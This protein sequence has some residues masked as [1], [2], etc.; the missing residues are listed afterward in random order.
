MTTTIVERQ[1]EATPAREK[2]WAW[3]RQH[4]QGG[5]K[6]VCATCGAI[7]GV[8]EGVPSQRASPSR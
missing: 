8:D 1:P 2:E 7:K 3:V 4:E 5:P 6:E